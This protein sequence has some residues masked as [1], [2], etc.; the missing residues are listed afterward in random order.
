MQDIFIKS[1]NKPTI[2]WTTNKDGE[3]EPSFVFFPDTDEMI[4][5]LD[6]QVDLISD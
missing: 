6:V 5:Y 3:Q 2:I 4:P 1:G